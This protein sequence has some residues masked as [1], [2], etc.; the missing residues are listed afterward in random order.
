MPVTRFEWNID[1]VSKILP[2]NVEADVSQFQ[3]S[4]N[5]ELEA[6]AQSAISKFFQE[7]KIVPSPF[8][9]SVYNRMPFSVVK[10]NANTPEIL[11][12][13]RIRDCAS[14]TMISIPSKLPKELEE[15]LQKYMLPELAEPDSKDLPTHIACTKII[16]YNKDTSLRR[17][18]FDMQNIIL[19]D[20]PSNDI[21]MKASS[22]N[23][24]I[25]R[26]T[27]LIVGTPNVNRYAVD[28]RPQLCGS[29]DSKNTFD[30]RS[31]ILN[32]GVLNSPLA[33]SVSRPHK[34]K[35]AIGDFFK[36][37]DN[38]ISPIR[39]ERSRFISINSR[40]S[41]ERI[42]QNAPSIGDNGIENCNRGDKI[43]T[44]NR[45]SSP[46]QNATNEMNTSADYCT[47]SLNNKVRQ[48]NMNLSIKGKEN[49]EQSI[50]KHYKLS[51]SDD[52]CQPSK[53]NSITVTSCIK[54][55]ITTTSEQ[56]NKP[57]MIGN[58]SDCRLSFNINGDVENIDKNSLPR[59]NFLYSCNE[60]VLLKDLKLPTSTTAANKFSDS[61]DKINDVYRV[62]SGFNEL[63]TETNNGYPIRETNVMD[64]DGGF[65]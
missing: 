25:N 49:N 55:T 42:E 34:R 64:V 60:N 16:D 7:N 50:Y 17:K 11:S 36:N 27:T 9:C 54:Q 63:Q 19:I 26:T 45:S 2:V 40:C 8:N 43:F 31:S 52:E 59:E 22:R 38:E 6:K 47:D 61:N 53:Q 12:G 32:A 5:P 30:S 44:P 24:E 57:E 15:V 4:P 29:T 58:G 21:P 13:R 37:L 20:S 65:V 62:D 1:E 56:C 14:Q 33:F 3:N 10:S 46:L 48:L 41:L 51:T 39:P 18:L 35:S 23:I 28:S